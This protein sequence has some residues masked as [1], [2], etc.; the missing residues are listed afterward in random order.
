MVEVRVVRAGRHNQ[1]VVSDRATVGQ[2][3]LAFVGIDA[4]GLT[5][6]HR[7]VA[8]L[9]QDRAQR[10][11]DVARGECAGRDLVQQR[12]EQVEVAA[13][14]EG[15][16]HLGVD[17]EVAGRVEPR[18]PS[19]D[20]DHP[21]RPAGL[22]RRGGHPPILAATMVDALAGGLRCRAGGRRSPDH[23]ARELREPA[24]DGGHAEHAEHAA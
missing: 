14:V 9:A 8:M 15:D 11:G 13:D 18:E 22:G 12:L 2:D 24:G 5:Q 21:M 20:D 4:L 7:R 6:D 19:P 1:R 17:A 10:L 3:D 16:A 23:V